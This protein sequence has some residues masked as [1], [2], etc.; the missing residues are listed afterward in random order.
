MKAK[1]LA[2][3]HR[4]EDGEKFRLKDVDPA[5]TAGVDVDK[6]DAKKLIK[7]CKKSLRKLQERL[8]AE[9]K[10]SV[11]MVL[12]A[13][14]AGGKDSA[15]E[16]VMSGIN[17]QGCDVHSFKQP[18]PVEL[19]HDFLWRHA[20]SLPSRGRIGIFNRSHY[21]EV[22]VVRVNPSILEARDLP[23][24]AFDDDFWEMRFE[25]IRAFERH[26]ANSRTAVLKVFL[27]ISKE[28]QARRFLDRIDEADKN[29]KFSASDIEVRERWDD[30]MR[31]YE[32][33]IRKTARPHAPWYVVPANNKWYARMV[34]SSVL[35]ETLERLDP[36]FPEVDGDFRSRMAEARKTLARDAGKR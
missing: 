15:I 19:D 6:S 32:D 33:M 23:A 3:R 26:L 21:E 11:L 25:D 7:D 24:K 28:E 30:Y 1:D 16:H 2:A 22:L 12:Q 36:Q 29:W 8:Y 27:H 34:I 35:T 18:G 31:A 14:D 5:D 4:V 20:I 17:P 10:S 13:M 9:N